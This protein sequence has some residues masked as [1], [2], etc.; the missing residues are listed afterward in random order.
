MNDMDLQEIVRGLDV[1]KELDQMISKLGE[2]NVGVPLVWLYVWD[3]IKSAYDVMSDDEGYTK[4]NPDYSIDDV[5]DE[6]WST[7][8]FSLEYGVEQ[9]DEEIRDWLIHNEFIIDV[10]ELEEDWE[11]NQV[12]GKSEDM[13][14]ST[15]EEV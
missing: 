5:W 3:V 6:L 7:P 10:E 1:R 13:L 15:G 4:A 11:E 12:D 2:L 14:Q 9:L 8:V